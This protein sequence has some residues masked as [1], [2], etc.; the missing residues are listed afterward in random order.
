MFKMRLREDPGPPSMLTAQVVPVV[1]GVA[2]VAVLL[3][4][5]EWMLILI[6]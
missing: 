1:A 6:V 4:I 2:V 5:I 3:L